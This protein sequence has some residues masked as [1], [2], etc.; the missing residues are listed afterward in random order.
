MKNILFELMNITRSIGNKGFTGGIKENS[1]N[2]LSENLPET[3]V[4]CLEITFIKSK[5]D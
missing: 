5:N 1:E 4:C 3:P 2:K